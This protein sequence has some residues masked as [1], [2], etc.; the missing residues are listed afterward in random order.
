MWNMLWPMLL[1][2]FANSV[3]NICAK[4][5]PENANAFGCL[6]ATYLTA[7][8]L[9][10]VFFLLTTHGR[11]IAAELAKINWASLV[12]GTAVVC[13]EFGYVYLY[14]AG[15]KISVGTLVANISLACVLLFIGLLLYKEAISL[16]Q[17]A[18]MMVCVIGLVLISKP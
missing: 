18:G 17:I 11:N 1:V 4:S 2:V 6:T 12:L 3:Y 5:T 9:S 15:W 7:A 14:R 8:L 10:A 16:R 13:L